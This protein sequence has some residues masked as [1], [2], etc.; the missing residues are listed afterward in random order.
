MR[1]AEIAPCGPVFPSPFST[2]MDRGAYLKS[3]GG[4]SSSTYGFLLLPGREEAL[5]FGGMTK[6]R[7]V[8]TPL[9]AIKSVNF[10][11]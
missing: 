6:A 10:D 11:K 4:A 1:G 3:L 2:T 9:A 8:A 5:F 7:I